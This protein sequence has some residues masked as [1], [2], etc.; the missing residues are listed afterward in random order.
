MVWRWLVHRLVD[1]DQDDIEAQRR[2]LGEAQMAAFESGQKLN[3]TR[4]RGV[5]VHRVARTSRRLRARNGFS[6]SIAEV[7]GRTTDD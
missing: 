4:V 1:P 7:F 3:A 5:E 6:E 2:A